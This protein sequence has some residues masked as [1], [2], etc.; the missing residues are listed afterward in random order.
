MSADKYPS[1]FSR[2]MATIVYLV[3]SQLRL[4]HFY[5]FD[6]LKNSDYQPIVRVLRHMENSAPSLKIFRKKFQ[7]SI[8]AD[9]G[10]FQE[11]SP[12][13]IQEILDNAVPGK[14]KKATKFRMNIFNG[15]YL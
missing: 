1:I 15:T 3:N 4:L 7:P 11:L 9:T 5:L 13:K 10:R 8:M 14:T 12:T 6:W 2:Q